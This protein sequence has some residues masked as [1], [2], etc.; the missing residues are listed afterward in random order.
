MFLSLID[1]AKVDGQSAVIIELF[2]LILG[3]KGQDGLQL[4]QEECLLYFCLKRRS[5]HWRP[6]TFVQKIGFS[7]CPFAVQIH[8]G[9]VG[10]IAF[11]YKSPLSHTAQLAGLSHIFL[12]IFSNEIRP[13][14]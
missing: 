9:Q 3:Q 2:S 11:S 5:I 4:R 7:D 6:I 1:T 12:T 13:C 14:L 8:Q 10:K